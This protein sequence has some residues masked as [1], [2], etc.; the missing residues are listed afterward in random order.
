MKQQPLSFTP[1]PDK[2]GLYVIRPYHF[3]NDSYYG[4][5][6]I[7]FNVSLD[8]QDCGTLETNSYLFGLVS[9]GKH[10]LGPANFNGLNSS[11]LAVHFTA[12][13]GKN[14]FFTATGKGSSRSRHL[15]VDPISETDGQAFVRKFKLSGDNRFELQNQPGQ[16]H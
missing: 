4:G 9:P 7:L 16:T 13:A 2:A 12:E 3:Y 10:A 6:A 5:S 11:S 1:P 8:Y 15:Q 14:Y